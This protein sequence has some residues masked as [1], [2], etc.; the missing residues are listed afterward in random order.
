MRHKPRFKDNLRKHWFP[1]GILICILLASI[2]PRFGSKD[3]PLNPELSV[4]YGA[5]SVIFLISGLSLKTDSLVHTVKHFRL[6]AFIQCF[7]FILVPLLVQLLAKVLDVLGALDGWILKG[8]ITVGCMPPPVSSA[9]IL[10]RAANG[11]EAAAIFNSVLGSFLGILLTPVLLLLNL[12]WTTLV[13]LASTVLQL[14]ITVMGPLLVGQVWRRCAPTPHTLLAPL[15]ALGQ[16][17]LLLIIYTTFCD[18]FE[19]RDYGLNAVDVLLTVFLVL[20]LQ[21]LLLAACFA[22]A[23]GALA[24]ADV[25]AALFCAT[26][27]SLTLG[28][29][30]LRI[31]FHGFAHLGQISLPLLIYHPTQIILGGLLVTTLKDWVHKRTTRKRLPL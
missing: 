29:P 2:H 22:L 12:G 20:L 31:M 19:S 3:G 6:H 18:S 30:I 23:E 1:V 4:K 27:K 24:P 10:T 14:S 9:V 25:A 15:N 13:P 11:N 7:S 17:A 28:V 8:L 26:H 5:V 16:A 21:M